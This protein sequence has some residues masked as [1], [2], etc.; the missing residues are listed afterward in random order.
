MESCRSAL[1]LVIALFVFA[2]LPRVSMAS[3][4]KIIITQDQ[5]GDAAKYHPLVEYL[6]SNGLEADLVSADDYNEAAEMFASGKADAMFSG[7]GVAGTLII[8]KLASPLVRPVSD[9]G[10]STYWAVVVAPKG[11]PRYYGNP[12]YFHN[13]RVVFCGLASS[14]EFYYRAVTKHA[15]LYAETTKAKTHFAAL[16]LLA[17]GG[18]DLA[19]VKNRVWDKAKDSMPMLESVGEDKE[20]NPNGTLMVSARLAASKVAQLKA[21]LLGLAQ[22]ESV[23]AKDVKTSLG[24]TSYIETSVADFKHT[25]ELLEKAGVNASFRF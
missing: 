6:K 14:G 21:I 9:G 2:M 11:A 18:A 12:E 5:A 16:G 20:Q 23:A 25:L 8:K 19:I 17:M 4:I 13:K 10:W 3:P 24:M 1:K 22:D 7:S 15:L